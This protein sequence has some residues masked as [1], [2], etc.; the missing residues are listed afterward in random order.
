MT[1]TLTIPAPAQFINL[2][3]RMHWAPK[4]ELTRKWRNAA[5]VAAHNAGF[6]TS[7]ERVRIVAHIHKT[8]NRE[9]DAHNLMPTLKA[10]VD[11]LVTDY[12]LTV[13]DTNRHVIGPD[14]RQGDKRASPAITL[15]ITQ[16]DA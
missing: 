8:T 2:N 7:L 5:H 12:G 9:Y 4:A 14:I 15:T 13:D 3:Q 6:P 16:E 11:G 10:C 1:L